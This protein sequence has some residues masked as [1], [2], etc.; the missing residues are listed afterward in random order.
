VLPECRD[1]QSVGSAD[2]EAWVLK[3]AFSNTGDSVT[4]GNVLTPRQWD[5][6]L[7]TAV[8]QPRRWVA[9]RRFETAP[10][11]SV[12]GP[13]YP[14]IG[15]FT[16]NGKAAGAY[17]R[18]SRHQLTDGLAPEAPLLIHPEPDAPL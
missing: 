13:V 18:L 15:M 9:Q 8:R 6:A 14:C 7:R 11:D 5:E 10:L 2:R 3:A 16:I 4:I 12:D 17:V 1:P